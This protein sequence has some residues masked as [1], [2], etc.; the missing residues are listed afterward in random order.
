MSHLALSAVESWS[1]EGTT[2]RLRCAVDPVDPGHPPFSD[3]VDVVVDVV[4]PDVVR[5]L[6]RPNAD[7]TDADADTGDRSG[8][9]PSPLG[10]DYEPL[11]TDENLRVEETTDVLSVSVPASEGGSDPDDGVSV[12]IDTDTATVGVED[13]DRT[14]V[15]TDG[16]YTDGNNEAVVAPTGFSE[17]RTDNWPLE[18]DRTNAALTLAPDERIYGGGERFGDLDRRGHRFDARVT[19]ANGTRTGDTYAP[20]PF[21]YSTRGY[22]VLVDTAADVHFD[23]GATAPGTAAV[24]VDDSVLA[25]TV[26]A[27]PDP[28]EVLRR[29]TALTGRP[30]RLPKWT[31]GVWYSRNTYESAEEALSVADGLRERSI[32]ADVLHL[33]PGWT[34]LDELDLDWDRKAFPDP[35]G[36]LSALADRG[37]HVSVWE[38]PY[39]K[40][41]TDAYETARRAGHLVE[42]GHGRPYIVRRPSVAST[43]A[44]IVDF[45]DPDAIAWWREKHRSLVET[46]VDAFKVDFGEYLPD[47]TVLADGTT[48]AATHNR[49]PVLYQR[50]VAGAFDGTSDRVETDGADTEDDGST[51]V[52]WARAGWTGAQRYPVHWG[53]DAASTF[54][55]FAASVRAGLS[56]AFSGFAFWSCDLGGYKP[57]PTPELYVRWA[58]WGLLALSHPRFHGK[59]PREPWHYGETAVDVVR[60]FTRLRYRLLP[61]Y[62]SYAERAART[63]LPVL[64]PMALAFPGDPTVSGR[65]TQHTVGR[66]LLLTPVTTPSGRV[67]VVLPG[68]DSRDD[69]DPVEWVDH[70]TGEHHVGPKRLDREEP[71][72]R[73]PVFVR[74]GSVLPRREPTECTVPGT[75]ET[76]ELSTYVRK[77]GPTDGSFPFYDADRDAVY[78]VS[79]RVTADGSRVDVDLDGHDDPDRFVAVVDHLDRPPETVTVNGD[80]VTGGESTYDAEAGR[81]RVDCRARS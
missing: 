52:L 32:P 11:R 12:T 67:S 7:G 66:E 25:L 58:Q 71:L 80:R 2:L 70:W 39:L 40:V 47:G 46:G 79:V 31:F 14:L 54:D 22:G 28:R 74:A 23:V 45:T 53:G 37:F 55:G 77:H 15:S 29:Y 36:T 18:V 78:E 75:P 44:G 33:D 5:V 24:G 34:D 72:D 81:L 60:E 16:A 8:S 49:Y 68:V 1:V 3:P 9:V 62:Y 6:V 10:L 56:L 13:G 20:V 73:L 30:P 27:G 63:G 59:T 26:F 4:S 35:E 50:A 69:E 51:P 65:A 64:R 76:V 57:D 61:F 43:R 41:G 17:A 38:Y 48:G 21:Y 19:Q 42:D